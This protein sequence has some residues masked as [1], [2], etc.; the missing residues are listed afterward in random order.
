V[1]LLELTKGYLEAEGYSVGQRSREI[2][3]G[4]KLAEAG[5]RRFFYVAVPDLKE[6]VNFRSQE[7]PLLGRLKEINDQH[8]YAQKVVLVPSRE[9][10]SRAFMLAA[11][12]YYNA[13]VRVPVQFFDTPFAWDDSIDAPQSPVGRLRGDG[14][15]GVRVRTFQPHDVVAGSRPQADADVLDV[16]FNRLRGDSDAPDRRSIHLVVGPAGMGKSYLFQCL[17]ARLHDAFI[18]DKRRQVMAARPFALL[19]EYL[20]AAEGPSVKSL[21]RAYLQADLV[22]S[23]DPN[24]LDWMLGQGFATLMLDGLDEV[25]DRDPG[26]FDYVENLIT[27]PGAAISPR[28]LICIRDSLLATS[29]G[30]RDFCVDCAEY[31]TIYRLQP[32]GA[33]SKEQFARRRLGTRAPEFL[34]VLKKSTDL[35]SLAGTAYYCD[36]LALQFE[37]GEL[38]SNYRE[39]DLLNDAVSD[40]IRR[41][42]AKPGDVLDRNV[43]TE[44]VIRDFAEAL[45]TVDFER[46]FRGVPA[47]DVSYWAQLSLPDGLPLDRRTQLEGQLAK[48]GLFSSSGFGDLR[49]AQEP[50]ELYFLG[51]WLTRVFDRNPEVFATKVAAMQFPRDWLPTRMIA[52]H[53]RNNSSANFIVDLAHQAQNRPVAFKNLVQIA[54][55]AATTRD[56]LKSGPF[57]RH[58]LSGIVFDGLDLDGVSFRSC[59]LT[60]TVFQ[61]CSLRSANFTDVVLRATRFKLGQLEALRG[62]E[63]GALSGFYSM[64]VDG[65]RRI[66]SHPEASRWLS[67]RT[68][69][70]SEPVGPCPTALQVRQVFG[71]F[72]YPNGQARRD[73]HGHK[74]LVSGSRHIDNPAGLITSLERYGYLTVD[75][76]GM[77]HRPDG[78]LY[79]DMRNF[80]MTMAVSSSLD[81][82]LSE[83][84]P[85]DGCPHIR[86]AA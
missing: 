11:P 12:Q 67:E 85:I 13:T 15:A 37:L 33:K 26:F 80:V 83:E 38:A 60:N 35:D 65:D 32:W 24:V 23:L 78:D 17:F 50:I 49:F 54:A 55:M 4:S 9:G 28:L 29:A 48:M 81:A 56:V 79:S 61:N 77:Y 44:E 69:I 72:I 14:R 10:L 70:P 76:R 22:R 66:G 43:A 42:Y 25:I 3:V 40:I 1:D 58:D 47:D 27:M 62:A 36:L 18:E 71:K 68:A 45:T 6:G 52:N 20:P 64:V 57:E 46:G 82:L 84:C 51:R 19:P 2:L 16:L 5:E 75:G 21:L 34:G 86:P 63:F 74:A 31:V 73:W 7:E 30:L 53:V 59:D 8:P 39:A 41:D